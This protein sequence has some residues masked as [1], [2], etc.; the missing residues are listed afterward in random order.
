MGTKKFYQDLKCRARHFDDSVTDFHQ[1]FRQFF[2]SL[3][4]FGISECIAV[5]GVDDLCRSGVEDLY[6][7]LKITG[8]K[9]KGRVVD[10]Q[11]R[12]FLLM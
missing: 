1:I 6:K 9:V 8:L 5:I 2:F 10:K 7:S 12:S 4:E 11:Y 3:S